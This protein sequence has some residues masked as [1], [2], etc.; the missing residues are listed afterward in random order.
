LSIPAQFTILYQVDRLP[1]A[2]SIPFYLN[3]GN[4]EFIAHKNIGIRAISEVN[5]K[6][7]AGA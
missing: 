7:Y 2:V 6:N 1:N 3:H 4:N 5:K